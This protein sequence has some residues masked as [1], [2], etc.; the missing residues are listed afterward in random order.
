MIRKWFLLMILLIA[1]PVSAQEVTPKACTYDLTSVLDLLNRDAETP[2]QALR[3]VIDARLAL[4]VIETQCLA[5]GTVL[6]DHTYTPDEGTFTLNYPLGW[7]VGMFSPSETGGVL[8]LGN[9]SL[10]DRLLQTAEPRVNAGEMALQ[11]LVGRPVEGG[12]GA[13]QS[14]LGEFEQLIGSLYPDRSTTDF[15]TLD[16]RDAARFS[17]RGNGFD[18]FL[19]VIALDDGRYVAIRGIASTGNLAGLQATAEAVAASVQ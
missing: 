3:H 15:F 19:V 14:V 4:Q 8:F 5:A 10:S 12:E 11:V 6:L 18:G 9:T 16:G 13:L 7:Q 2:E 1:L 17:Y